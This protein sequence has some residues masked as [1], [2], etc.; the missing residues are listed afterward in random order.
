VIIPNH[1]QKNKIVLEILKNK[2]RYIGFLVIEKIPVVTKVVVSSGFIGFTVVLSFLNK[3]VANMAV[4]T[5]NKRIKPPIISMFGN[6]IGL[7]K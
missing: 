5:P 4:A 7:I 1:E 3:R 2:P 6:L